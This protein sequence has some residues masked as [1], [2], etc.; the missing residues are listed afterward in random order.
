MPAFTRAQ[1]GVIL[2]LGVLLSGVYA[3]R[4]RF[5]PGWPTL[6]ART[7]PSVF[8]EVAGEVTR[9]GVYAFPAPP[10][11]SQAWRQAG[12]PEPPPP[13]DL[14][15]PSGSRIEV[16]PGGGHRLGRMSG[17]QLLTLGLALDL[18]TATAAD[19]EALPGIGPVLARRIVDHRQ[20]RG[21]FAKID[22]LR[23]I[24]GL[25]EK[26]LEQLRP[27]LVISGATPP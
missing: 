25:G 15:L 16:L 23:E 5:G 4:A 18:N 24:S 6:A 11:L 9:P 19:L 20:S 1:V 26:K 2:L 13:A 12:G 10:V 7:P 27:F 17:A 21:A 3:W 22:D 14:A 8:V